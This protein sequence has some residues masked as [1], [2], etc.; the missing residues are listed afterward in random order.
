MKRKM[1]K[2]IDWRKAVWR[3]TFFYVIAFGAL[4]FFDKNHE[5]FYYSILML[6]ALTAIYLL[7]R[8]FATVYQLPLVILAGFVIAGFMHM[9]GGLFYIYGTR[10][11]EVQ[12]WL[13]GYDNLVH[14]FS[15]FV[16][17]FA[18][19]N[20]LKPYLDTKLIENKVYLTLLLMLIA[21]GMGTI[22]EML[23][24]SG[25]IIFNATGVGDYFNNA[26]D[27]V[28][29]TIG[30]FIGCTVLVFYHKKKRD[31][32]SYILFLLHSLYSYYSC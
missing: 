29:N 3:F 26:M 7:Q 10:L 25:V 30:A 21:M 4:A 17:A 16:L 14:A 19:Y 1:R 5:F 9:A 12:I 32:L 31:P 2:H 22:V 8:K 27:L 18:A 23:E 13:L 11:Y 28:F 20:L 24:L 15:S 6:F